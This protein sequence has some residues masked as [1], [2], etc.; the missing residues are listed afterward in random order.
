MNRDDAI[1]V[2]P[3]GSGPDCVE[4]LEGLPLGD[5]EARQVFPGRSTALRKPMNQQEE[6]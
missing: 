3:F 4:T 1:L 5:Q 6:L 2:L